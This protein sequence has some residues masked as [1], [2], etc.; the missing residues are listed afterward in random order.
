MRTRSTL[1]LIALTACSSKEDTG[2]DTTST[3]T[4]DTTDTTDTADTED[5]GVPEVSPFA[6]CTEEGVDAGYG[7]WTSTY[8][9]AGNMVVY[10][11]SFGAT[12]GTF[13]YVWDDRGNWLEAAL[14]ARTAWVARV[15]STQPP[16][17]PGWRLQC[18]RRSHRIAAMNTATYVR[19]LA[20]AVVEM[21][22]AGGTVADLA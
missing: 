16:A 4:A 21:T 15:P 7:S 19:R 8:D 22:S 9:G 1:L 12:Y 20:S 3:D 17:Q 10:A 13:T 6:N 14:P 2:T 11:Y 5:S 18:A